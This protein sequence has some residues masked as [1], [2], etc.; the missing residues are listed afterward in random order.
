MVLTI[1]DKQQGSFNGAQTHN[2]HI[3]SQPTEAGFRF[4]DGCKIALVY[5]AF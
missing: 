2:Q 1:F 4:L 5:P 3:M